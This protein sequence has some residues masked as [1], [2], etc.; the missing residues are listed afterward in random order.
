M[1]WW[2]GAALYSISWV[3]T[4]VLWVYGFRMRYPIPNGGFLNAII[5]LSSQIIITLLQYPS[6]WR[7]IPEFWSRCK[8]MALLN[9]VT[10]NISLFYLVFWWMLTI[11]PPTYQP[12]VALVGPAARELFG[13]LLSKLGTKPF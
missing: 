6:I 3:V 2:L 12:M 11:T 5:G 4:Y 13:Y 8:Y 9:L 7:K 10:I 1:T